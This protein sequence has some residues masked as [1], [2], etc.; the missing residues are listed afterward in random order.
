MNEIKAINEELKSVSKRIRGLEAMLEAAVK[1][2]VAGEQVHVAWL[3]DIETEKRA[4]LLQKKEDLWA[5]EF[6]RLRGE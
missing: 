6:D 1:Y 3:I 2:D 4:A 5:A